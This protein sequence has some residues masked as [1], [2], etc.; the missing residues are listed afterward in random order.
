MVTVFMTFTGSLALVLALE[1][2]KGSILQYMDDHLD[3]TDD[4]MA[5]LERLPQPSISPTTRAM[6]AAI[7]D[8]NAMDALLRS[9]D[10]LP[11]SVANYAAAVTTA[12]IDLLRQTPMVLMQGY[13]IGQTTVQ[14]GVQLRAYLHMLCDSSVADTIFALLMFGVFSAIL[15]WI[16]LFLWL[17]GY[18]VVFIACLVVSTARRIFSL[19]RYLKYRPRHLSMSN[20]YA[21]CLTAITAYGVVW[22]FRETSR[23]ND[24]ALAISNSL[25]LS[26]GVLYNVYERAQRLAQSKGSRV[27][28]TNLSKSFVMASAAASNAIQ[29]FMLA[30]EI[31]WMQMDLAPCY[32]K[33]QVFGPGYDKLL[34]NERLQDTNEDMKSAAHEPLPAA[35]NQQHQGCGVASSSKIAGRTSGLNK[36]PGVVETSD[37]THEDAVV[38]DDVIRKPLVLEN[39]APATRHSITKSQEGRTVPPPQK[40]RAENGLYEPHELALLKEKTRDKQSEQLN[41]SSLSAGGVVLPVSGKAAKKKKKSAM[42]SERDEVNFQ[43]CTGVTADGIK[44][45]RWRNMTPERSAQQWFCSKAHRKQW[46]DGE[47]IMR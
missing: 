28:V 43:F 2:S 24:V 14:A 34:A 7:A 35:R 6:W 45:N 4:A 1:H 36:N 41:S 21:Q 3:L 15:P 8:S 27:L 46:E 37:T 40:I 11:K 18:P 22:Y 31:V 32:I 29:N 26:E 38:T 9:L 5:W 20:L 33:L 13:Q 23:A 12:M 42:E 10:A 25:D 19:Q 17:I 39:V 47:T 44:C 16:K 30:Q